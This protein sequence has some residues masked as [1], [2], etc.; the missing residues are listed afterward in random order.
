MKEDDGRDADNNRFAGSGDL[1]PDLNDA[2][3]GVNYL[4]LADDPLFDEHIGKAL[5]QH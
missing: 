3:N 2:F 4:M 1:P 5:A